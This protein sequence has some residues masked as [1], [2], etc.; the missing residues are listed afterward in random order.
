M[1]ESGDMINMD[2]CVVRDSDGRALA[3]LHE[4]YDGSLIVKK[5]TGCSIG[6]YLYIVSFLREI[7]FDVR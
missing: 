5:T 3:V 2:G 6:T 4:R 1:K 7:G